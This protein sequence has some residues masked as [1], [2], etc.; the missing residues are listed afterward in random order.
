MLSSNSW[1]FI[2]IPTFVDGRGGV[3]VVEAGINIP[4][5]IRRV[6]YLYNFVDGAFRGG[7]SHKTLWTL[8]VPVNGELIVTVDNASESEELNLTRPEIGLLLGPAVW[9]EIRSNSSTAVCLVLASNHYDE[10]DYIRL[11]ET[12]KTHSTAI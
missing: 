7:H 1:K 8:I 3:S 6:Y 5:D 11:Y 9:R 10:S 2:D 4:F 12:F